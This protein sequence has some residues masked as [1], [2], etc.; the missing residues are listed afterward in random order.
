MLKRIFLFVLI[1]TTYLLTA[2]EEMDVISDTVQL[3]D[4]S[5]MAELP[6]TG[7]KIS[8]RRLEEKNMG[9]DMP[10]LLKNATSVV[11]T[12]DAG[13]G[14]GY[15][16]MRVRGIAQNQIN[17]TFNGVPVNDSESHG[18]FWVDFPD[19]ASSTDGILI[20][21]GVGTSSNGAAAFGGSI[22][23]ETTRDRREDYLGLQA[24]MGSFNTMKYMLE[25]GTGDVAD[26][27][28]NIDSRISYLKS[29]GY[30]ERASSEL[31]SGGLNVRFKP[32][33]NTEFHLMN[34][35]GHE[36][37]YQAWNGIDGET[38]RVNRRFNPSGA[39]YDADGN[40]IDYYKDQVDNYDQNHLHFYWNQNWKNQWKST[41]TLHWTR[42]LG[43]YEEYTQDA[44]FAS[45][46]VDNA[47]STGDLVRRQWLDNH[48]FGAIFNLQRNQTGLIDW[49]LGASAN[50]YIGGHY[51][52]VA[53]VIN[54]DY[55]T[56]GKYYQNESN[57]TEFSG[58]AK[59]LYHV[60]AF[61][62]FGDIQFRN[63]AYD[64][65]YKGVRGENPIKD[66]VP[67][68]FNWTFLNPKAGI[69]FR[70]ANSRWYLSYGMT[71]REPT[72]TDILA[73]PDKVVPETLHDFELG[74]R[75]NRF[76]NLGIN[77][78]YMYY[79]D[80]L[81]LTGQ[82]DDVGNAI[83]ENVG[84]S[85][86]S[87][88]ELDVSKRFLHGKLNLFG[89]MNLSKNQNLNYFEITD[90]GELIEYGKTALSYTPEIITSFGLDVYPI[91]GLKLNLTHQYVGDQ[92]VTNIALNDGKLDAYFVSDFMAK[93]NL[94][95]SNLDMEI[96]FL[97]NNIWNKL[98]ANNG[99][100]WGET[101]Y[102]PQAGR[103]FMAGVK[104][105]F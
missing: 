11:A 27:K 81:V 62:L 37:T 99:F 5:V 72:R 100:Y 95:I 50:H 46:Y 63:I 64:A 80:Q 16:G 71:H 36:R 52:T 38:M 101:Y 98:Y 58:F 41:T 1:S 57:K 91:N 33:E 35:L 85:Y 25:A 40:V 44:E 61:E 73:N 105:R 7:E 92:F 89:N 19:V 76:L 3:S 14:I 83:R 60:G 4:V 55:S 20:Q 51:G 30:I 104:F 22:N 45:Y 53:H 78:Y 43:F 67:Y 94:E 39:I 24:A 42:G 31:Y 13:N 97:L 49:F 79:L 69:N 15:T 93:Y 10:I 74:F 28:W 70:K 17:V 65:D 9:Q 56:S 54:S 68:Q 66:F 23:L 88:V 6:I 84:E 87:G 8:G 34:L 75:T 47:E 102:Y 29:D 82:L 18:V 32:N 12:S 96:T 21:R 77:L 26:G 59:A 103:N 48:F 86:R 90:S 2:Q